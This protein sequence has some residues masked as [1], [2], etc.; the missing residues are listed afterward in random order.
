MAQALGP[1]GAVF[2]LLFCGLGLSLGV[3]QLMPCIALR[4]AMLDALPFVSLP[5]EFSR[6]QEYRAVV[7]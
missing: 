6:P 2:L 7:G 3:A 4:I 5:A 1:L